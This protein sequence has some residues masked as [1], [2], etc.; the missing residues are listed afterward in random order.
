MLY[1]SHPKRK[2]IK[3]E[4]GCKAAYAAATRKP[5]EQR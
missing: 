1:F 2:E 4:I 3:K 5:E